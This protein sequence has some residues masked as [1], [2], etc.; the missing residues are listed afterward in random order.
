MRLY[1]D[2][3][4]IMDFLLERHQPSTDLIM[5]AIACAHELCISDLTFFELNRQDLAGRIV[6]FLAFCNKKI[7]ILPIT[8]EDE[9]FATTL[10]THQSDA[11]HYAVARSC[12]AL[13]TRNVRDFPFPRVMKPIDVK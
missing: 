7:S 2:T 12:D 10:A 8:V 6:W 4:V 9:R 1:L 5:A 3:N 13:V 11:L